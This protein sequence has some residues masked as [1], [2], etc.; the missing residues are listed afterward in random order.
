[1]SRTIV[2]GVDGRPGGRDALALARLLAAPGEARFVL[3][4][5]FP[6]DPTFPR[7]RSD[8]FEQALA[9][10]ADGI[11]ERERD[12]AGIDA[13]LLAIADV[14]AARALHRVAGERAADLIVVGSS[15]RGP[16]GRLLLGDVARG[17]LHDAPCP[18]AVAP[19]DHVAREAG[20]RFV[21]VG[22]DGSPESRHALDAAAALARRTGAVV[23]IVGVVT[24]PEAF[25]PAYA[26]T[27]D[28][29]EVIGQRRRRLDAAI[30]AAV[31]GLDVEATGR[32]IVG[33]PGRALAE[34]T[35][36]VDVLFIGS[37][38]FGP[39]RR[40]LL[41][42]TGDQLVEHAHCPVVVVPRG[43]G[44]AA[45]AGAATPAAPAGR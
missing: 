23:E 27:L 9:E 37:R 29:S 6:Y 36:E 38:S 32:T 34:R 39:V 2:V 16:V 11:L 18:V 15:H 20:V 43:T 44:E 30:A 13:D 24:E 41:G 10:D 14:H 17:T 19:R 1:M 31:E 22:F 45:P 40:V 7:G 8:A 21:G 26:M 28:W 42:S 5:A 3:V 25:T 12:A 4:H 35:E 33:A